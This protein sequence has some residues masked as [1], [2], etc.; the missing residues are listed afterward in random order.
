MSRL[1]GDTATRQHAQFPLQNRKPQNIHQRAL[2]VGQRK[3]AFAGTSL[4]V[5]ARARSLTALATPPVENYPVPPRRFLACL[6]TL[7][8]PL[9]LTADDD[10]HCISP[11]GARVLED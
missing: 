7:V 1:P 2:G 8:Q 6:Q 9:V 5:G 4:R 11:R 3:A 10:E